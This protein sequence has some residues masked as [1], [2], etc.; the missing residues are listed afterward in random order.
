MSPS[1]CLVSALI[2]GVISSFCF[3]GLTTLN[4][5]SAVIS[6]ADLL[7][8]RKV[9]TLEEIKKFMLKV[10]FLSYGFLMA[11]ILIVICAFKGVMGKA[12]GSSP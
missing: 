9:E 2:F 7:Q 12:N 1:K 5:V 3:S 11:S 6:E 8:A 4:Q 10:M